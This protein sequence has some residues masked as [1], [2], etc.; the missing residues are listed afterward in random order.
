MPSPVTA[1]TAITLLQWKQIAVLHRNV[2]ILR[3]L[4]VLLYRVIEKSRNPLLKHSVNK[5]FILKSKNKK[6]AILYKVLETPTAFSV[7][8]HSPF[9]SCPK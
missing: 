6:E 8:W 2:N 5:K 9:S 7:A 3:H 1:F 4:D